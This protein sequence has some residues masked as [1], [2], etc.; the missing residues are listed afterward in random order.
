MAACEDTII[1]MDEVEP[2]RSDSSPLTVSGASS[3][4]K[5]ECEDA[6]NVMA[7]VESSH[8]ASGPATNAGAS[9]AVLKIQEKVS[10]YSED[11]FDSTDDNSNSNKSSVE[12]N[13]A[14][15]DKVGKLEHTWA[16]NTLRKQQSSQFR[17]KSPDT[18][19]ECF[20]TNEEL[21]DHSEGSEE[22]YVPDTSEDSSDSSTIFPPLSKYK[23]RPLASPLQSTSTSPNP[24]CENIISSSTSQIRSSS[25]NGELPSSSGT[26]NSRSFDKTHSSEST[27]FVDQESASHSVII[28]TV[29][30]KSDGG[31]MYDKKQHCLFCGLAFSKLARHLERKHSKEVEVAKALSHPKGSKK[32]RIQLEYLRNKD[33]LVT[34]PV[35]CAH[36]VRRLSTVFLHT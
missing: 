7:V 23:T 33:K 24:L 28:P 20:D 14:G 34:G 11:L 1:M 18:L 19:D 15:A 6:A 13:Q 31:R 29:S 22:E 8:S 35:F 25:R 12:D 4:L 3:A 21:S 9:S 16:G 36:F 32:R 30:K 5:P 27:S 2:S 10:D 17:G 26:Q